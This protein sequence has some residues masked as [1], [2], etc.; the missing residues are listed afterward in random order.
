MMDTS[1]TAPSISRIFISHLH[2]DHVF[3]LPGLLCNIAMS[4]GGGEDG[5]VGVR[6]SRQNAALVIVGPPGLRSFLRVAIGNAYASL[7]EMR[8]VI[9]ELDGLE[10]VRRP[11]GARKG[12]PAYE[13]RRPLPCEAGGL[14]IAPDSDGVWHIPRDSPHDPPASVRA[15]ELDH[16][17][18][19]VGW[20]I[21]EDPRPGKVDMRKLRPLLNQHRVEPRRIR[22]LKEGRPVELPDGAVLDPADYVGA[23][24]QRK[25]VV[26]SDMSATKRPLDGLRPLLS[27]ATLFVHESTNAFTDEDAKG[28]KKTPRTVERDARRHGH[29]TP[30]MAGGVAAALDARHLVLTHFSPRYASTDVA[31]MDDI[32]RLARTQ[33]GGN[34]TAAED[35][36]RIR[37]GIDGTVDVEA[38]ASFK[39]WRRGGRPFAT[40]PVS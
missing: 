11:K 21:E 9:H 28:G 20:V 12:R 10:A 17:V 3:G 30:Q 13:V 16:T 40:A 15:V 37:V 39:A 8:L 23:S 1:I 36:M 14:D 31:T 33:F 27:G 24:T 2:G 38:D 25:F 29:S 22:D 18:P 19:T 32:K 6:R 7:G 26:L 34:V 35:L 5:D 4:Y